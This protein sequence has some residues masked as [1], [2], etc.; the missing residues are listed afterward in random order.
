MSR[1]T[2]EDVL[3][4]DYGSELVER[5]ATGRKLQVLSTLQD[6]IPGSSLK[7]TIDTKQ[8]KYAQKALTWAMKTV[9]FKRGVVIAMN[10]QTGEILALVSLPTYDDNLFAKGISLADFAKLANNKNKPLL[11]HAVQAH[12][13]PGST[14]KLV[15]GTAPWPTARSPADTKVQ[16]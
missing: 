12:Y 7:L 5:D 11:D 8:Q 13:A 6:A 9:G 2:F 3:R 1:Q 10:P 4:G 16:T 14:Y 15:T